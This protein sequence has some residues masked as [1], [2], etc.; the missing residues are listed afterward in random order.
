MQAS[1]S[2]RVAKYCLS[3]FYQEYQ[4][5]NEQWCRPIQI[6]MTRL[7]HVTMTTLHQYLGL[8]EELIK[9]RMDERVFDE[10]QRNFSVHSM[11]ITAGRLRPRQRRLSSSD[12]KN[13]FI[14]TATKWYSEVLGLTQVDGQKYLNEAIQILS[15]DEDQLLVEQ[16]STDDPCLYLVLHGYLSL[17]QVC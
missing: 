8:G 5:S 15:Y 16:G 1:S 3:H 14:S 13:E 4:D 9:K 12:A 2:C 6:I 7:L 11:R 17:S 10:K